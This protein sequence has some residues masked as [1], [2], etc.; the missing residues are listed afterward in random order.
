VTGSVPLTVTFT[1]QTVINQYTSSNGTLPG[2][3]YRWNF[4]S[5]SAISTQTNPTITYYNTGSYIV[6]LESTGSYGM[7][8]SIARVAVSASL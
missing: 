4:G 6:R 8:S 7:L 5:G 1:N 3:T 2:V